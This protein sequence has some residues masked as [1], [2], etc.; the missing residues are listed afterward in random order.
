VTSLRLA[1][2]SDSVAPWNTGG[3]ER[4]NHELLVRLAARG[5]AVDVYTM[6]WWDAPG[7]IERDGITYHPICRLLPLY[8]GSR[9]SILQ[10]VVFAL[11]SLRVI[12]R[13]FDV[14]EVD[15]IP[16][17]QLFP[18]R[19]V[20]WL[21]RRPMVVT[22]HEYWGADY[23]T[24]YL[25]P[26]GR[27]A[28]AVERLAISLP[29]RII[30]ASHGTAERLRAA[31]PGRLD[32]DVVPPGVALDRPA[33]EAI[34][35]RHRSTL[36]LLC[37]GRLLDHKRVDIAIGACARLRADGV[38][39]RLTVVGEGPERHRLHALGAG[40][41]GAVEFRR[42]LPE[43]RDILAAMATA[44]LLVFPSVREGFGM[45]ALEAMAMGTPV[46]TSD[47]PDNFARHIVV[48]GH[49]GRVC[50]ADAAS[51]AAAI[52]ECADRLPE[53]SRGALETARDY[54]WTNLAD[55]AERAYRDL[56]GAVLT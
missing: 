50:P 2:V 33:V 37:V 43:H 14:L 38:D 16:F 41:G 34:T 4:R 21:R 10:A 28:A 51:V 18:M 45:V 27:I 19:V 9:R 54:D 22:W 31:H 1:V 39:A 11:A 53:L 13:R 42:F 24:Q 6:H 15:A 17:L 29:D 49:N 48:D 23:W 47:H 30:A 36:E 5:F 7:P 3:K 56:P 35:G 40:L 46:V 20:A 52:R 32:I 8:A 12:T 26:L 25:G 44:D 55:R